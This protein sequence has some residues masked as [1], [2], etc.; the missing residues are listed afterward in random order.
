MVVEFGF[1]K[2]RAISVAAGV[3]AIGENT[4]RNHLDAIAD[5]SIS[6]SYFAATGA[7]AIRPAS[8]RSP[9][10]QIEV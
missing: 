2:Y 6:K 8:V 10:R 1:E 9:Q 7:I 4:Y 5:N 3:R